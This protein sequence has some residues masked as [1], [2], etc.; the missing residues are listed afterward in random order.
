M[1][2][3]LAVRGSSYETRAASAPQRQNA[4]KPGIQC[5]LAQWKPSFM[6]FRSG[7]G[8]RA[9]WERGGVGARVGW[10]RGGWGGWG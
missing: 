4:M 7:V 6:A 3:I 5:A 1:L 10:E 2:V 9:G 8:A